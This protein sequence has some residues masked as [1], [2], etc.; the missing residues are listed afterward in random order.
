MDPMG[1]TIKKISVYTH[2][3]LCQDHHTRSSVFSAGHGVV[4]WRRWWWPYSQLMYICNRHQPAQEVN[5]S[6]GHPYNMGGWHPWNPCSAANRSALASGQL[7]SYLYNVGGATFSVA[8]SSAGASSW[9]FWDST[10][11]WCES[12][13]YK[14]PW[15]QHQGGHNT[16]YD[17]HIY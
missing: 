3:G 17:R 9:S 2:G 1:V 15:L 4:N 7:E 14:V 13:R 12:P 6:V 11:P 16:S 10:Y 5:V 8:K